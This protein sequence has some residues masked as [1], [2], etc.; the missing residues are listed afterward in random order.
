MDAE[1]G[2]SLPHQVVE[3]ARMRN[4]L[5]DRG[6]DAEKAERVLTEMAVLFTPYS[7]CAEAEARIVSRVPEEVRDV[8]EF[9][10]LFT[11]AGVWCQ[12]RPVL[13]TYWA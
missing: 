4:G 5:R 13:Y 8:A 3:W 9:L 1:T 6:A 10:Q 12:L 11:H 2:E 7:T